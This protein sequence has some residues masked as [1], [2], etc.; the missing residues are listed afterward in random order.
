VFVATPSIADVVVRS[1]RRVYVVAKATGQTN[2]YFYDAQGRQIEGLNLSISK[3]HKIREV[4]EQLVTVLQGP[5]QGQGEKGETLKT[6]TC[7][8]PTT[9]CREA[10]YAKPEKPQQPINVFPSVTSASAAGGVSAAT[11]TK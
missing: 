3:E 5:G 11:A 2:V 7:A 4:P 10:E 6:Y 8:D 9:F 1:S